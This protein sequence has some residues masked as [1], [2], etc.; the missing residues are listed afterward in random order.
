MIRLYNV[1]LAEL[2]SMVENPV[3]AASPRLVSAQAV[4]ARPAA[5]SG[6]AAAAACHLE[7]K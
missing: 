4:I 6:P 7:P 1:I 3:H 2:T 5:N